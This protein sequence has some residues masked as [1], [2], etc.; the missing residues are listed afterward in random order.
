[1]SK[2]LQQA[3]AFI[4]SLISS[5][6]MWHSQDVLELTLTASP[7]KIIIE[8]QVA[9]LTAPFA[10]RLISTHSVAAL[11]L[12]VGRYPSDVNKNSWARILE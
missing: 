9:I 10:V 3:T 11:G 2:S 1:M 4:S 6:K 12:L 5:P 7:R 8:L